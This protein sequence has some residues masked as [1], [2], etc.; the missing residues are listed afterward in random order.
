[1]DLQFEWDADKAVSNAKKHGVNFIEASS[2]F[3][4]PY[5]VIFPDE[6]HSDDATR[7]L[8]IGHSDRNRLLIVCFTERQPAV[9][10]ISARKTTKQERTDYEENA[11]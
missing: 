7:E 4:D 8:I 10:I 6:Q 1:M 2:V 9:R 3:A 5:A 11:R